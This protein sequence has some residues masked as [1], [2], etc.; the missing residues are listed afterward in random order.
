MTYKQ[1]ARE[2]ERI[3]KRGRVA[4]GRA[5]RKSAQYAL[6]RAKDQSRGKV[7]TAALRKGRWH[8]YARRH[9]APLLDPALIN[10][11]SGLFLASWGVKKN[12]SLFANG[13]IAFEIENTVSYAQFMKGTRTMHRR[14]ID[15][16]VTRDHRAFLHDQA[17]AELKKEG[18]L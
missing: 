6:K 16:V 11:Q 15:D 5:E 17:K 12:A 13:G 9:P 18:I 3:A 7:K 4:L 8:P 2:V 14:P 1:A 10:K